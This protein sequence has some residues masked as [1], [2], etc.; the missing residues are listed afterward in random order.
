MGKFWTVQ[1]LADYLRVSPTWV[2]AR[3]RRCSADLIPH[4]KIGK[5]V[6]FDLGAQDFQEWLKRHEVKSAA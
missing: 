4:L 2:Y 3:T 5:Y 6:R 1:Q